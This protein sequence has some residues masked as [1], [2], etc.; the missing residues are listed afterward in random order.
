MNEPYSAELAVLGIR[1][2][3][4]ADDP[5][6]LDA[7]LA[8]YTAWRGVEPVPGEAGVRLRIAGL[9]GGLD[10]AG[11]PPSISA[12]GA[13]LIVRGPDMAAIANAMTGA[14]DAFVSAALAASPERLAAELLDTLLLFMLTRRDRQP[15]HAAGLVRNGVAALL[16]APSGV[17][18]S[19]LAVAAP[20]HGF[21]LLSDD[22]VYLESAAA[23]AAG[24]LRVWG[25]PRAVHLAPHAPAAVE[26]STNA[27]WVDA[28]FAEMVAAAGA[29]PGRAID[30]TSL[31]AATSAWA[32]GEPAREGRT[33]GPPPLR[34]RNGRWKQAHSL[35]GAWA[36]PPVAARGALFL[37][38]R[39]NG[40]AST[41]RLRPDDAVAE[42]MKGLDPGFDAFRATLPPVLQ[43]LTA[44]GAWQLTTSP[45]PAETLEVVGKVVERG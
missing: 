31:P 35:P 44:A 16:C 14:G 1:T 18:K 13:R 33:T 38:R 6:L 23:D 10:V 3:F 24:G 39:G 36:S 28:G 12:V 17:G 2:R 8:G 4:V 40:R 45:D 37:L 22:S 30:A 27:I 25:F 34:F 19:T 9:A 11:G 41:R 7:A 26:D 15:L 20:A 5:L 43:R 29:G 32:A 21:R 42:V